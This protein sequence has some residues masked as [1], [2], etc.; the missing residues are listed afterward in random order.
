MGGGL[1][2]G[3]KSRKSSGPGYACG[4]PLAASFLNQ[5]LT[6]AITF[7]QAESNQGPTQDARRD[8]CQL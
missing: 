1:S 6:V 4:K 7:T 2:A 8:N 3:L 5:S